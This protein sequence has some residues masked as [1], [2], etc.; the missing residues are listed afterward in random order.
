MKRMFERVVK[1]LLRAGVIPDESTLVQ[2]KIKPQYLS[3]KRS[4][5]FSTI[6]ALFGSSGELE[7]CR[8]DLSRLGIQRL[9]TKPTINFLNEKIIALEVFNS[10]RS[11]LLKELGAM[12][13]FEIK[14][15]AEIEIKGVEVKNSDLLEE[16]LEE[17]FNNSEE[18]IEEAEIMATE[19]ENVG[20]PI[21]MK[22][23][24]RVGRLADEDNSQEEEV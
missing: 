13:D 4:W 8:S 2:S 17:E 11:R 23:V 21:E 10:A 16:Q 20:G 1:L 3:K 12:G 9:S 18:I 15:V 6:F 14:E 24:F 19:N 5:Q 7:R 22:V